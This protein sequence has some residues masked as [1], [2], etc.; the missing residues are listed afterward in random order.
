MWSQWVWLMRMWA[1]PLPDSNSLR[2][3]SLPRRRMP[4]PASM[5]MR[6]PAAELTSTHEVLP[7]YRSVRG[8]GMGKEP[9]TPQNRIL[10]FRWGSRAWPRKT[11]S[12]RRDPRAGATHA[13]TPRQAERRRG[14]PQKNKPFHDQAAHPI[15]AIGGGRRPSAA[16]AGLGSTAGIRGRRPDEPGRDTA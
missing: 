14:S 2:I 4:V 3:N 5:M 10:M 13:L 6:V 7:P 11:L 8:P 12:Q 1:A 16:V 9:L 15:G